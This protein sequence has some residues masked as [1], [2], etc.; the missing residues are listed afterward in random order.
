VDVRLAE[1]APESVV[2]A[3]GSGGDGIVGADQNHGDVDAGCVLEA[4][5]ADVDDES[6]G[7]LAL[8]PAVRVA[9][10]ARLVRDLYQN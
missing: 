5:V 7:V 10:G 2:R 4:E 8:A 3:R 1:N 6:V 9:E